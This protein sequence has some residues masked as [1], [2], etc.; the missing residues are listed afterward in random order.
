MTNGKNDGHID[1]NVVR[2]DISHRHHTKIPN[3]FLSVVFGTRKRWGGGALEYSTWKCERGKAPAEILARSVRILLGNHTRI[4][5]CFSFPEGVV[6][7]GSIVIG[8][9]S[10]EKCMPPRSVYGKRQMGRL[11]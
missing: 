9:I 10:K 2:V 3:V 4:R 11:N 8:T 5:R 1:M 6:S 7:V